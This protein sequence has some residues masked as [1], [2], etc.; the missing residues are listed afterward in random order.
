MDSDYSHFADDESGATVSLNNLPDTS[1]GVN[2]RA[3][4]TRSKP[5][6]HPLSQDDVLQCGITQERGRMWQIEAEEAM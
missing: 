3:E 2:G 1:H 6:N 5:R 4:P